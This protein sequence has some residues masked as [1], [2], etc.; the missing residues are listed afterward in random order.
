LRTYG[1]DAEW[2]QQMWG[3]IAALHGRYPQHLEALKDK[4]WKD[5]STLETLSA[6]AV[7][8]AELED[9]RQD[10]RD[11]RAFQTQL[12]DYAQLLRQKSGDVTKTWKP[13][14]TPSEWAAK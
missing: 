6:R 14:A 13:G 8:R 11:E 1:G 7:W 9:T 10:P 4:W 2:R 3:A 5:E 12:N